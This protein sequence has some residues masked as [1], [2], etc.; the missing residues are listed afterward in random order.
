MKTCLNPG[1]KKTLSF[2]FPLCVICSHPCIITNLISLL[3]ISSVFL[4]ATVYVCGYISFPVFY[5]LKVAYYENSFA[6]CFFQLIY[7]YNY[8]LTIFRTLCYFFFPWWHSVP[9]CKY[10]IVYST[11]LRCMGIHVAFHFFAIIKLQWVTLCCMFSFYW[12][13]AFWLIF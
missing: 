7:L 4:F 10:T 2:P 13:C 12:S 11:N 3:I 9:L 5:K 6:S 8:S 1:K